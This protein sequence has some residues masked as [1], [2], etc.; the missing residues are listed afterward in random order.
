MTS[1]IGQ[2]TL[3][4]QNTATDTAETVYRMPGHMPVERASAFKS[5]EIQTQSPHAADRAAY[6]VLKRAVAPTPEQLRDGVRLSAEEQRQYEELV[7]RLLTDKAI[8]EQAMHPDTLHA[9]QEARAAE[10]DI[11]DK[12][13]N[14]LSDKWMYD[15]NAPKELS[16][17]EQRTGIAVASELSQE[18]FDSKLEHLRRMSPEAVSKMAIDTA[19]FIRAIRL[20]EMTEA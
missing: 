2:N 5:A 7:G 16:Y 19:K 10:L 3:S 14:N 13:S 11:F 8:A 15:E 17:N 4:Q 12:D 1:G 6:E 9:E 20:L 18:S